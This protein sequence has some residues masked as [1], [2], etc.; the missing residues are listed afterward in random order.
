MKLLLATA[1]AM[2]PLAAAAETPTELA[3]SAARACLAAVIDGAPVQDVVIDGIRIERASEPNACSVHADV[4]EPAAMRQAAMAAI[5][6]RRELFV[7]AKTKWDAGA[8]ASREAFCNLPGRRALNV[9]VS[10]GMPGAPRKLSLIVLEVQD[11]DARCDHDKG[12]Q[13]PLAP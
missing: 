11:R 2:T 6:A 4:G 1:I 8:F 9:I 13:R 7:P 5:S 10:T 12:L 3:G